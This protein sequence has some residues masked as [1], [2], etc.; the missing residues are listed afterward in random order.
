MPVHCG[1]KDS[2]GYYCQWGNHGKK[3]YYTKGNKE[4]MARARKKAEKQGQAAHAS[5]YRGAQKALDII[6]EIKSDIEFI[7]KATKG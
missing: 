3:Y 2:K 7:K 6:K 4:S 5:G 1:D